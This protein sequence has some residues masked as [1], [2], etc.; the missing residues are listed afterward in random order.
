[1]SDRGMKKW[2]AYRSLVEQ[3]SALKNNSNKRIKI[4]KPLVSQ[5]EAEQINSILINYRGEELAISF[6]R[7]GKILNEEIVIKKIDMSERKLV[8]ANRRVI[9]FSEIVSLEVK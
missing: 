2:L 8:L 3:D 1:M 7:D 4:E 5:D 6:F 9:H